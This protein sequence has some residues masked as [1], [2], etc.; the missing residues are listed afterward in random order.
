MVQKCI[1]NPLTIFVLK[2]CQFNHLENCSITTNTHWLKWTIRFN[3]IVKS[4]LHWYPSPMIGKGYKCGVG[5][6]NDAW[7]WL[8]TMHFETKCWTSNIA[9]L[10]NNISLETNYRFNGPQNVP[11]HHVHVSL[12]FLVILNMVLVTYTCPFGHI[13]TRCCPFQ[14]YFLVFWKTLSFSFQTQFITLVIAKH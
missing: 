9:C 7:T 13:L 10:S 4:K 8:H 11:I 1:S 6:L 14:S 2:W 12:C 3:D 5:A